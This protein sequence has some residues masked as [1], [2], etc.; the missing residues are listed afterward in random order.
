VTAPTNTFKSRLRAGERLIGCWLATGSDYVAEAMGTAGFDWLVVDGEHVPN[1]IPSI[2]AQLT[3]LA[4]SPSEPVVRLPIGDACLI[5]QALDIGAQSLLIPMVDTAEQAENI[6]RACRYPPAGVR[7]VGAS[8]G[9]A[10]R[11]ASVTDYVATADDQICI[12]LQVESVKGVRNLEAICGVEGVDGV[13]IG[14]S[15]LSTDMGHAGNA[16]AADVKETIKSA[17]STIK[18]SGKAPGILGTTETA[19]S[20]YISDGAQFVAVGVD[21]LMML[22][23]ARALPEKWRSFR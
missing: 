6:V 23:Q 13:F 9:R 3:A 5:K 19:A 21:L 12:L 11:F 17:L 15:D 7:G 1:D 2:R 10:T 4:A 14:P 16:E 20:R 22:Q 18:V 8:L